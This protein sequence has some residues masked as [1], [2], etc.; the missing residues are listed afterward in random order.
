MPY[1]LSVDGR[2]SAQSLLVSKDNFPTDLLQDSLLERTKCDV[3]EVTEASL[4]R[5]AAAVLE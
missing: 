3:Y 4:L 1:A 5:R 2:A